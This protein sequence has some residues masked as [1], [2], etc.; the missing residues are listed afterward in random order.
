MHSSFLKAS[1]V[2]LLCTF[3]L[4]AQDGGTHHVAIGEHCEW[5][6]SALLFERDQHAGAVWQA[7]WL[8]AAVGRT[9]TLLHAKE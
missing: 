6:A 7:L 3:L 4:T 5:A 8:T 1:S 9:S 2:R